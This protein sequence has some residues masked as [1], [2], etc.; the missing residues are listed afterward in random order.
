MKNLIKKT[1][2]AFIVTAMSCSAVSASVVDWTS[3]AG[4]SRLETSQHKGDFFKLA[5]NFEAQENKVYCGV[6]STTIVLNAL[7]VR[8]DKIEIPLDQSLVAEE[9]RDWFP[10]GSFTPVYARYTQNTTMLKSPKTVQHVMGKPAVEGGRKD[11]G[12]QL[13]EL[14]A[15]MEANQLEAKAVHVDS[16]DN[17]QE[18]KTEVI[19]TLD[20]ADQYVLINYARKGVNQPGGGHIS[21]IGAYHEAS[22]SFLIMDVTPNKANWVWVSSEQLFTA[23]AT[24]DVDKN[25]GYLVVSDTL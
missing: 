5:N 25:R 22:D 4:I 10:Q 3:K 14:E 24:K 19:N 13:D 6:A 18:M 16:L 21:P 2:A 12:F 11:Y 23:L 9:N 20:T 1:A 15:M 7:R 8:T 17:F